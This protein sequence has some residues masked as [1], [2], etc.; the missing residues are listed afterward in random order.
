MNPTPTIL[1]VDD[2]PENLVVLSDLL[3]P[4]YR[5]RAA[6]NGERAL[7]AVATEPRPDLIL[8]DVMMPGM[9]GYAV[10]MQ[11]RRD[12]LTRDIPVIFVTARDA[13][14]D[15]EHGLE[16]GAADYI[17]K[18]I[19][20][21]IVLAR[22]RTQLENKQAR[23]LL[24]NQN[25][26]LEREVARRMHDNELI[27]S[28]SVHALAILAET[29]DADTG[30]HLRRT[31]VYVEVLT[32]ALGEY[33]DYA[34]LLSGG[35]A[36]L[37]V[38]AAPLHDIGKVGIPDQV[39]YK[40][41]KLTVEEYRVIQTHSRIGGDAIKVA[42]QRVLESDHS[43]LAA[44]QGALAFLE[45]A[46]EIAHWH[47]ERWDGE[48]YPD[49]LQGPAIPLAARIMAVADVFDALTSKRV[50]KEAIPHDEAVDIIRVEQGRQFDPTLVE[51]FLNVEPQFAKI[52]RRLAD[53]HWCPPT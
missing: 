21:A 18:P 49:R 32:A 42:M 7:R 51:I 5:V 9:D 35:Q 13:D 4:H 26:F 29:R 10:L 36:Q 8:L 33:P 39:L 43:A 20:A 3:E 30:N 12:A 6:N 27:Q 40:P 1:L 44:D 53:D 15:E 14:L 46:G 41:A 2:Q 34:P 17:T 37:I 24:K 38:R 11:L 45:V 31:Q 48:G 50:Y 47:H 22:V 52:A 23:D 28:A 16:M 19:N 25:A